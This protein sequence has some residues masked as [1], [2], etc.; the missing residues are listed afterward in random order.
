MAAMV[1]H[2]FV[3]AD[4]QELKLT[5]GDGQPYTAKLEFRQSTDKMKYYW[6]Y[7]HD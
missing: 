7:H 2:Y 3:S 5:P 4:S 6:F 1:Q